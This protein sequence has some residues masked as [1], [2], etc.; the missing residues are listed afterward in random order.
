MV[1]AAVATP[2]AATRLRET[3]DGIRGAQ[4]PARAMSALSADLVKAADGWREVRRLRQFERDQFA[5]QLFG[6]RRAGDLGGR[7]GHQ[8][9]IVS[10]RHLAKRITSSTGGTAEASP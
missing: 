1:D 5:V 4:D 10:R 9:P 8:K 7:R 6:V 3:I 2:D